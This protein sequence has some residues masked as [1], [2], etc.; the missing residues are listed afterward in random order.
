VL[1]PRYRMTVQGW[2]AAVLAVGLLLGT[3][4][5]LRRRARFLEIADAHAS[6]AYDYGAGRDGLCPVDEWYDE[7]G[8]PR[9]EWFVRC[10]H[11]RDH[12]LSLE[13]KYRYAAA[14]PW[15]AVEADPPFPAR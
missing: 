1:R 14:H 11:I 2:M 10:D 8:M 3:E 15:L 6:R 4:R 5:L 12:S 7:R 13:R 9:D